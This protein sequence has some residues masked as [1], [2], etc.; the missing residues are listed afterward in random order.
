MECNISKIIRLDY[1]RCFREREIFNLK[2]MPKPVCLLICDYLDDRSIHAETLT[3][4]NYIC[5]N[6]P[7]YSGWKFIE[8]F[9][10]G[11]SRVVAFG[12]SGKTTSELRLVVLILSTGKAIG[13]FESRSVIETVTLQTL[14]QF[15]CLYGNMYDHPVK[16]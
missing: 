16:R 1:P 11:C 9:L 10:L 3:W 6:K 2:H 8:T 15:Q 5:H 13:F 7:A 4:I 12:I 14:R